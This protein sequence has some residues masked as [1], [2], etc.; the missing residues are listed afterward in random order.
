MKTDKLP[1]RLQKAGGDHW[2][3]IAIGRAGFNLSMLLTPKNQSIAVEVSVHPEWKDE[4]FK[5]LQAQADVIHA[6]LKREL[7][8]R[9]MPGNKSARILLEEKI[10]PGKESNHKDVCE[11][12][13]VWTPKI[14]SVFKERI[15]GLVEPEVP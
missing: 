13:K 1:F 9:P 6:E 10:D 12:F 15:K 8:W 11:W 3:S 5:Q 7:D 14:Y 2:S 4:A